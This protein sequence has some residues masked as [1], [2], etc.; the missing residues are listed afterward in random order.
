MNT[1]DLGNSIATA[2]NNGDEMTPDQKARLLVENL[3]DGVVPPHVGITARSDGF[4]KFGGI[5]INSTFHQ[6]TT[7]WFRFALVKDHDDLKK[8]INDRMDYA[9][10]QARKSGASVWGDTIN[11]F[12]DFPIDY[13]NTDQHI[14]FVFESVFG[15]DYMDRMTSEFGVEVRAFDEYNGVYFTSPQNPCSGF[16][17]FVKVPEDGTV[18][19]S[20]LRDA[21]HR[22]VNRVAARTATFT[23][24][25]PFFVYEFN[26]PRSPRRVEIP[27]ED[28]DASGEVQVRDDAY[29]SF[30]RFLQYAK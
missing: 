2:I 29:V 18:R 7:A 25:G 3:Y 16:L 6:G 14:Q 9:I 5:N 1:F 24:Q 12:R 21:L 28:T 22:A 19:V 15:S 4:N 17:A 11:L 23:Q 30:E 13:T 8:Q 27:V 20:K 10:N 26:G